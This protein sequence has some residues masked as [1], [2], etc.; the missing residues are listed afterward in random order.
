M[1]IDFG[2]FVLVLI[3]KI[4][5]VLVKIGVGMVD[6]FLGRILVYVKDGLLNIMV[7]GNKDI[8]EKVRFVLE[9]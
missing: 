8:F 7:V 1:L 9:D 4:G 5:E 3:W 6:V 2:I